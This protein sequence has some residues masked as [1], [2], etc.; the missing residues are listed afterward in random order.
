[1]F[2]INKLRFLF[3]ANEEFWSVDKLYESAIRISFVCNFIFEN[4][5]KLPGI[6]NVPKISLTYIPNQYNKSPIIN[7]ELQR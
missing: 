3:F 1:M 6:H 7:N 5:K 2:F 4:V